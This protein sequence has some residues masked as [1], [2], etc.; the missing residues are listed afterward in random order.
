MVTQEL[1][2]PGIRTELNQKLFINYGPRLAISKSIVNGDIVELGLDYRRVI[3]IL[4]SS[5][6]TIYVRTIHFPSVFDADI[7]LKQEFKLPLD[8]INK[9]VN[10]KYI[11]LRTNMARGIICNKEVMLSLI[12]GVHLFSAFLNKF[13]DI[14]SA[15]VYDD[16]IIRDKVNQRLEADPGYKKYF[17]VIVN[18]GYAEYDKSMNLKASEKLK[19]L[20]KDTSK[21]KKNTTIDIIDEIMFNV[22]KEN[23]DYIIHQLKL[24]ILRTYVNLLSCL[25]YITVQSNIKKISMK[26]EDLFRTYRMF[27]GNI[28]EFK[29]EE[30]INYLASAGIITKEKSIIN[31]SE[32]GI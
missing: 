10:N 16:I 28:L 11:E 31:W 18:S 13:N 27:Y 15:L 4:D 6:N 22:I 12:R 25:N 7:N 5:T 17:E 1:I 26:V 8:E 29:F 19:I 9:T 30:R 24:R 3:H 14:I 23:Y 2:K 21:D 20:H 32:M